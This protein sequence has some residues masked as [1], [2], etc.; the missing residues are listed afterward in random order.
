MSG[1]RRDAEIFGMFYAPHL[2][3]LCHACGRR[4]VTALSLPIP[5]RLHCYCPRCRKR[6]TLRLEQ[7]P[8]QP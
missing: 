5:N 7:N 2:R 6:T 4:N 8:A 1:E 3:W